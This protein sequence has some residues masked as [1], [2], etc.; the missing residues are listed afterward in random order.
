M[1]LRINNII[2]SDIKLANILLN[3]GGQCFYSDFGMAIQL[4]DKE[5]FTNKNFGYTPEYCSP[6]HLTRKPL[7][8]ASDMYSFGKL[9]MILSEVLDDSESKK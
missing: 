2:H 5:K 9:L 4:K 3:K 1:E 6:E 7:S 8:Y